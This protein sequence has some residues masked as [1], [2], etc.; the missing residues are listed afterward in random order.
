MS[1]WVSEIER[2]KYR[3]YIGNPND[4]ARTGKHSFVHGARNN[5]ETL[6]HRYECSV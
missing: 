4:G 2:E 6:N 1:E 5:T 3:D